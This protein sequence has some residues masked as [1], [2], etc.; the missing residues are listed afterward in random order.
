MDINDT[1]R[2]LIINKASATQMRIQAQRAGMRTLR[3][4]GI[5]KIFAGLS[6]IEEVV[7]E[8]LALED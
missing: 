7:K 4:A 8:T 2:E 3:D 1:I 5:Q 6:T